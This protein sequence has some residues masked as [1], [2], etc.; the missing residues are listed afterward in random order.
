MKGYRRGAVFGLTVAEMFILLTFLLLIAL[1]GLIQT[2]EKHLQA[3][4]ADT[5][6]VPRIWVRPE[7]I[8]TLVNAAEEAQRAYEE[9]ELARA[10][11]ERE[12]DKAYAQAEKAQADSEQV[13]AA[14]KIE[15]DEMREKLDEAQLALEEAEQ[16]RTAAE[17]ER[18][19]AY[20]QAEKAQAE[21][22]QV[23][24]AAKIEHDQTR[25]KLDEAQLA[26]EEAEQV[27]AVA[28]IEREKTRKELNEAQIALEEAELARAT[29]ARERD[30]AQRDL[31]LLRHKG[32]NPPCW[33]KIVNSSNGK[34]REKRLYVF[35]VAIYEDSIELGQLEPPPGG[36]FDDGG[37]TYADE[38]KQL[39][40]GEL[41]YGKK[42]NDIEFEE[43]VKILHDQ[44]KKRQVRTYECV[45]S[46]RVWDKTPNDA[47]ERWQY[48]HDELIERYFNAYTVKDLRWEDVN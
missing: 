12:R 27:R 8:H 3:D 23:R 2:E 14:A 38:W 30:Y 36:A 6:T 20:A 35:K 37:K 11:A 42:L 9:A 22:E 43:A 10:A 47:K 21:S 1:L 19:N 5:P 25:E 24:A 41:P 39:Q 28:E 44:G 13:R 26:L 33:Y 34:T 32:E 17:R 15:R 31:A 45:F 29:T 46:V 16:A 40:V 18:E 48:A 4:Q 7:R